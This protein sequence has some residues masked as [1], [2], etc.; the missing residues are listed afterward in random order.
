MPYLDG[1]REAARDGFTSG[2]TRRNLEWVAPHTHWGPAVGEL[3]ARGED[4]LIVA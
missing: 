4:D 1:A 2:G 3:V